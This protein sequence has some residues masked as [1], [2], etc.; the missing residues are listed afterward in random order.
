[1]RY[2]W[3]KCFI[4][5]LRGVCFVNT[6]VWIQHKIDIKSDFV[7][8]CCCRSLFLHLFSDF[9]FWCSWHIFCYIFISLSVHVPLLC[10]IPDYYTH[11]GNLIVSM[12]LIV[13]PIIF[14]IRFKV[15]STP[16]VI[17]RLPTLYCFTGGK[18]FSSLARIALVLSQKQS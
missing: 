9:L 8:P 18:R 7:F 10:S 16:K 15:A 13:H 5:N 1:M 6:L 2:W 3:A 4:G 11:W 12:Y 14:I 17:L